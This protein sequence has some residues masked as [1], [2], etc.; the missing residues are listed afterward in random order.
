MKGRIYTGKDDA[1]KKDVEYLGSD[2]ICAVFKLKEFDLL[3]PMLGDYVKLSLITSSLAFF[4]HLEDL[5]E[6][7]KHLNYAA[8]SL[9]SLRLF[10]RLVAHCSQGNGND[11]LTALLSPIL[12]VQTVKTRLKTDEILVFDGGSFL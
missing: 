9:K 1:G 11:S 3:E 4:G 10:N 2:D 12:Q 7:K 8:L 5:P 6:P